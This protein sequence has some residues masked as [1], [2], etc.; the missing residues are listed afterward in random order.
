MYLTKDAYLYMTNFLTDKDIINCLSVNKKF[1][2]DK[3]FENMM[4]RK[5]PLLISRN[6]KPLKRSW[7]YRYVKISYYIAYLNKL[8]IPYIPCVS[9]DPKEF[10]RIY[11]ADRDLAY[12]VHQIIHILINSRGHYI[13]LAYMLQKFKR[14]I[15]V[16]DFICDAVRS[17]DLNV[18]KTLFKNGKANNFS[19]CLYIS[20]YLHN[21]EIVK[22]AIENGR[23]N[24]DREEIVEA[25]HYTKDDK[26]K[27]YLLRFI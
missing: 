27:T 26:I 21:I 18:I 20:S 8:E 16:N 5:Y 4:R 24:I 6:L 19:H 14:L 12:I 11:R 17:T 2:N 22:F 3:N 15:I 1:H 10:F 13:I 25:I 7:K 9:F 23:Q